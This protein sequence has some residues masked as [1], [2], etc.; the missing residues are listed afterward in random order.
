MQCRR[1][2]CV[3]SYS[4][5]TAPV[6]SPKYCVVTGSSKQKDYNERRYD[7]LSSCIYIKGAPQRLSTQRYGP[8][9]ALGTN[10]MGVTETHPTEIWSGHSS[11]DKQ[12][13]CHRHSPHR[14]LVRSRLSG[15]TERVSQR[16]TTQRSGPVT[17]LR[18]NRMGVTETHH[19]EIWTGHGCQD[20]QNGCHRDS[21]HR[22]LVRSR[23]SGQTEWVSQRLTTQRSGTVTAVRTNRMGVTET[24][25]TEIWYGDGCQDKQN[26]C[27]RDSPHRDLVRS[28]LSGQTEWVSQTH[29]TEIWSGH[30]SQDKQ[31]E[32]HRLTTQRS[33]TVTFVRT[34]TAPRAILVRSSTGIQPNRSDMKAGIKK[35]K[36]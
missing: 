23:L 27:H 33:G 4:V 11:Q 7:H 13:G 19:T 30:S 9:S 2:Y 20:K 3:R 1:S 25:H 16:L 21:P 10:R 36:K 17:T 22:D 5:R 31:N 34:L 28:Q 29:H 35:K 12:N 32:C 8:V 24:H 18:T 14:D 15:Q 6:K 26:E